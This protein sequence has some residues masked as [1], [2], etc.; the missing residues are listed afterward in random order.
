MGG[1]QAAGVLVQVSLAPVVCLIQQ[2]E[3]GAVCRAAVASSHCEPRS[4]CRLRWPC[5]SVLLSL[6]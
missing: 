4:C 5:C 2:L 1:D 3:Q 6:Q